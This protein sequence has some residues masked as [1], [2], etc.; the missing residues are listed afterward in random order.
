MLSY[1]FKTDV[2]AVLSGPQFATALK[3]SI[4]STLISTIISVVLAYILALCVVRTQVKHKTIIIFGYQRKI[5]I[6]CFNS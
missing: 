2:K 1:L 6:I 3:N 5:I 4:V